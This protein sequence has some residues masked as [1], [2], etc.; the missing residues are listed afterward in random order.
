MKKIFFK[1]LDPRA[2][3]PEYMTPN[4]AGMDITVILDEE[5]WIRTGKLFM[6][7]T[8][9]AVEMPHNIEAQ[10]RPRSGLSLKY[11]NYLA[12]SPGTIDSDYRG[13]IKIPFI[14]NSPRS[15]IISNGDRIA[16]IIFARVVHVDINETDKLSNTMRSAGG[17]GHTGL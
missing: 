13:E 3:I 14:N 1:K 11:P 9:L 12:N 5:V 7:S 4:S 15:A 16:Q 10:V 2:Q 17:F 8:G 6:L